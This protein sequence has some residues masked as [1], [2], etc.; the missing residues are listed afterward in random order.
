[1]LPHHD[2]SPLYTEAVRP[3][4]GGRVRVWVRVPAGEAATAVHVRTT[5]DG[6]PVFTAAAVDEARQGRPLGGY[7]ASD[8]WWYA[9][10]P[11][12]NPVTR[13]RFLLLR[14]GSSVWLN[15]AGLWPHDVPDT[16]DFRL[17]TYDPGP[18]WAAGAIVYEIFPDRFARAGAALT[19]S[20]APDWAATCD[21][22]HDAVVATGPLTPRQLYGGNLDGI[23][24][25]LDHLESL[26]VDTVYLRPVFP[27]RSNHRYDASSFDVV[28]PLLGGDA[29]LRRLAAAVH[30]R[31]MRLIG[32][33]TTN[34]CGDSH[35]WF[36]AAAA[37]QDRDMFYFD[38]DGGYECWY[39][40]PT[41]PKLNWGSPELR[42][43]MST[44][45]R[46]WLE[47]FDGWRVD[48]ANMTGRRRDEERTRDVA[49]LL[50]AVAT[51]VRPDALLLAEH[52]YDASADLDCDGW[53]GHM[54]YAGFLRPV[55]SWLRGSSLDL[56]D[57]LG[58]P[59]GVPARDGVA[60]A[61]AMRAFA[62]KVSWATSSRSWQLVD[63]YDSPRIRTV[64]GSRERQL[65]AVGLQAT[66]PGAA[67]I[68]GGSEFGLTGRNGEH[69]RTPMPWSR[70]AD[71]DSDTL[72]TYRSLFGLRAT[73][74]ALRRGGLRWLHAGADLLVYLRETE[75]ESL[76]VA[77]ARADHPPV[78]LAID[79]RLSHVYG[80]VDVEPAGGA[81]T[82]GAGG[83]GVRVWRVG[84]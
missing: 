33:I 67:M 32:D 13:Y 2:G 58:V 48:V 77:V 42:A 54:N 50:R 27:S 51:N 76:L 38:P 9:D 62:A 21:W 24:E 83:A 34:H 14:A 37:G 22:D 69:A 35:E 45:V 73:E 43:R 17:V 79:T 28:D 46:R 61:A 5:P 72:R 63:S 10:V 68:C 84:R 53:H 74:P 82:I 18:D 25:H 6:D 71:R 4:L 55:W 11:V 41:L 1:M 29:A 40:I 52:N 23:V 47:H 66:L 64:T 81:V 70:P 7:G 15:A 16:D 80:C 56:P 44:V 65:L 3:R 20:E 39:G 26:P 60:T 57:F 30:A 49:A 31:G 59:G 8:V 12:H 19:P 78:T 75:H 36:R